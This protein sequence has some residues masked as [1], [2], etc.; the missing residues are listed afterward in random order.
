[1]SVRSWLANLFRPAQRR[2]YRRPRARLG[3]E[4]CEDRT[5]PA[6]T[7]AADIVPGATGSFP[8]DTVE[9]N[10]LLYFGAEPVADQ[11]QLYCYNPATNAL[12]KLS[13]FVNGTT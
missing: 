9:L 4:C 2:P 3:L 8:S 12:T 7:L 11:Q 10:G 6:V 13:S 1:M 5:L